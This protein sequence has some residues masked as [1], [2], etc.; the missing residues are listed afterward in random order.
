V[1]LFVY[2]MLA[3]GFGLCGGVE[4]LTLDGDVGRMN[5]VFKFY[6]HV[7]MMW[8]VAGAFGLWYLFAVMRPQA[9]LRRA[10]AANA[11]VVRAPR[12]AFAGVAV[13]AARADARVP[14]F[15][16]R[17]RLRQAGPGAGHRQRRPGVPR[18]AGTY[19]N[20]T[21]TRTRA[22]STS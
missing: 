3:L 18:Q 14:Y 5:T 7:W 13:V 11:A 12:H 4:I 9:F 6:L 16:T 1:L 20:S 8:G 21:T 2:A 10:G 15:G 22:A 17:A 19:N